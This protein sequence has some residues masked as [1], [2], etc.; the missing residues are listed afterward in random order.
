M[1]VLDSTILIDLF[2]GNDVARRFLDYIAEF[3][4]EDGIATTSVSYYEIYVGINHR[5]SKKEERFFRKMSIEQN[6]FAL[7]IARSPVAKATSATGH[8]ALPR[9]MFI[10]VNRSIPGAYASV[11]AQGYLPP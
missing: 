6:R 9:D 8:A 4:P 3:F 7:Q 5:K 11:R 1:I 2:Q 10:V